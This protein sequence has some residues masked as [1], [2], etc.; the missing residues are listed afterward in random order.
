MSTTRIKGDNGVIIDSKRYLELPKGTESDRAP[1]LRA[2]MIR[3]N[4]H[5]SDTNKRGVEICVEIAG[6][7]GSGT[8]LEWRPVAFT[9]PATGKIDS[10][11]LPSA[12]LGSASYQ[13]TWNASTNS[14]AIPA[15]GA[16]G[17]Y[18]IVSVAGNGGGAANLQA[19][20]A[21]YKVGDWVVSTGSRWDKIDYAATT[22]T[23]SEV[24][25]SNANMRSG[26]H[27]IASANLVQVGMERIVH[28]A[29]DRIRGDQMENSLTFNN[30]ASNAYLRIKDGA[31]GSPGLSFSTDTNTGIYKHGT[32]ELAVT[33][34]GS[35]VL[36]LGKNRIYVDKQIQ[37]TGGSAA[38]PQYSFHQDLDCGMYRAESNQVG[39][40]TGAVNRMTIT[41]G[42]TFI[43]KTLL[44]T[45]AASAPTYTF[46]GD[47]NTGMYHPAT[48]QLALVT[49]GADRLRLYNSVADFN[50]KVRVPVGTAALPSYTFEGD[51][52]TGFYRH[53][54]DQLGL[55]TGGTL[56]LLQRT[57]EL[58]LRTVVRAPVGTA[59]APT[60]SFEGDTNT[61][62]FHQAAES[63]GFA[64][65][66]GEK[67]RIHKDYVLSLVHHRFS[68]GTEAAPGI[69][70]IND[71]NTGMRLVGADN[72]SLV[73][74]G[75]DI[76]TFN[77]SGI[78]LG[79][80]VVLENGT[81]ATP[82]LTF[83]NDTD[84]GLYS[85]DASSVA[86]TVN[87]AVKQINYPDRT[88]HRVPLRGERNSVGAPT[89]SFREDRDTGMYDIAE[90]RLGFATGAGLRLELNNL[91][92]EFKT[93]VTAPLG[94]IHTSP[95]S[96]K[97]S[98]GFNGDDNTGMFSPG[99]NLVGFMTGGTEKFRID[100]NQVTN[101]LPYRGAN[102]SAAAPH[103]SF[104]SSPKTGLFRATT[105][106]IGFSANGSEAMRIASS[107]VYMKKQ[108]HMGSS[109]RLYWT[110]AS[111]RY[112]SID[113]LGDAAQM[114]F[115]ATDA[116][117]PF[118]FGKGSATYMTVH[119]HALVLPEGSAAN[120]AS[121]K[122][123]MI[124][125]EKAGERFMGF[126]QGKWQ[127]ISGA[128]K[129]RDHGT[130]AA[131]ALYWEDDTNTG[132]YRAGADSLSITAGGV[133][134]LNV[135]GSSVTA[136]Q[137][138]T[139]QTSSGSVTIG[140]QNSSHM[141]FDTDRTNFY[142]NK[143]IRVNGNIE[144]YNG[145]SKI[146]SGSGKIQENGRWL[147]DKYFSSNGA[148]TTSADVMLKDPNYNGVYQQDNVG[149]VGY[150]YGT[151]ANMSTPAGN[152]QMYAPHHESGHSALYFRTGWNDDVKAWKRVLCVGEKAT[153]SDKLDNLNSTQFLRSDVS[154]TMSQQLIFSRTST[155]AGSNL[156]NA[157]ILVGT[158]SKGLGI[159]SNK[160]V[161]KGDDLNLTAGTKLNLRGPSGITT[162]GSL[163]HTGT[164]SS[165]GL[166][167]ATSGI[168]TASVNMRPGSELIWDQNTD[169]AKIGFDNSSDS[170][171]DSYMYFETRDNGNEYFKFRHTTS[172]GTRDW[173]DIKSA[174]ITVTGKDSVIGD[175]KFDNTV[176]QVGGK[177][178]L[179]SDGTTLTVGGNHSNVVLN[180]SVT[181]PNLSSGTGGG[182]NYIN[183]SFA[184]GRYF[185]NMGDLGNGVD[186][187][188]KTATGSYQQLSNSYAVG[189]SNYPADLA[190]LLTVIN[191]GSG[192]IYQ[193][194]QTYRYTGGGT[195]YYRNYH[196]GTWG[197]W[198]RVTHHGESHT[199][200]TA[201]GRFERKH[202]KLTKY[203]NSLWDTNSGQD[204]LCR[205]KRAFVGMDDTQADRGLHINYSEDWSQGIQLY[206]VV[207]STKNITVAAQS[208]TNTVELGTM[209]VDGEKQAGLHFGKGHYIVQS[210]TTTDSSTHEWSCDAHGNSKMVLSK[211][212]IRVQ[213][214][215]QLDSTLTVNGHA[216][217][218]GTVTST[219]APTNSSHLAN[220]AY[221]DGAV[222][223]GV[224]GVVAGAT[225]IESR[226]TRDTNYLPEDR[227]SGAYFDFTRN[228]VDGFTAGG[229]SYHGLM[230]FRPYADGSDFS[231]GPAHQMAFGHNGKLGVRTGSSKTWTAWHKVYTSLDKPTLSELGALGATAK[232]VDSDKL[233]GKTKAQVVAEAKTGQAKLN[234]DINQAFNT[235]NL[236]FKTGPLDF[237]SIG[238]TIDGSSTHL[239]FRLG[240]DPNRNDMFRWMFTPTGASVKSIM[241]L[242]ATGAGATAVGYL[243]VNG[244][245]NATG[246][247]TAFSDKRVKTDIKNIDNALD[248]VDC[249]NGVTY[250][251]TDMV[252]KRQV[253]LIAQEVEA[254]LPEAVRTVENKELGIDDFKTV[255][256]GNVSALL[257]EAVKEE[258]AK[259]EAL[260]TEVAELKALVQALLNK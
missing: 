188:T 192:M 133:E 23:A 1:T 211:S 33:G 22:T 85:P 137:L 94:I 209:S 253:G 222:A 232:A 57:N 258:K 164:L 38:K 99:A 194:Y 93:N 68:S 213:V 105:D 20:D 122:D 46:N 16:A 19:G 159:D 78:T 88:E 198:M 51:D 14:P 199:T 110:G 112:A 155:I 179:K 76:L 29:V 162:N 118:Q 177:E 130:A 212:Q 228:T 127:D 72:A 73:A 233:E 251:R 241:E 83:A 176:L 9:N 17:R 70:F 239:D 183:Q 197:T 163:A 167:T 41:D 56:R 178:A 129:L 221:V 45:G 136:K 226:D 170:D 259:R 165:S 71:T 49:G 28:S 43:R 237:A 107:V 65:N 217:I 4:H 48:D 64:A 168:T 180:G 2:G 218:K 149:P 69:T 156:G 158:T 182:A 15:P 117:T 257:V 224:S 26:K 255:A 98:F 191:N 59:A 11:A 247:I 31:V 171:T 195:L 63:I 200:A 202:A 219:T 66:G 114:R 52:N 173:L 42:G 151:I 141:H 140:S 214:P 10:S 210:S 95:G 74:G 216:T 215:A 116:A 84:S 220:K 234:G 80:C 231:G 134:R 153:D 223:G 144:L 61:G 148:T 50:V 34:G 103:Y 142:F 157:A 35:R 87:K 54:S 21:P 128:G 44:D 3:Y 193:Q 227:Q 143:M 104:A 102:G 75:K 24:E 109:N 252:D 55:T 235:S 25:L 196:A 208:A 120:V 91:V 174:G 27:D 86:I 60:Y 236:T 53:S 32:D 13:G 256:Y 186:L 100:T 106:Q 132:I 172:S 101:N 190:G 246:N 81:A 243:K 207:K 82:S 185:R 242:Y 113:T 184:D 240:D 6:A 115:E 89:Y 40:A 96:S 145:K 244:E 230:T 36:I 147:D 150:K 126:Y 5:A 248:K 111:G 135:N 238:T 138:V 250:E 39:F 203:A 160:I 154:D 8:S 119:P 58:L 47:T 123:G 201:D 30:A 18:Y 79:G 161:T 225:R 189:G 37:S 206:G 67:L 249:L 62:M 90:N 245:V 124:R 125:F 152:F 97:A 254:V 139:I 169:G 121:A 131:P 77:T 175:W 187:N 260:E 146:D 12:V 205:G 92:A 108:L 166:V 7:T 229:S 181:I 204:L